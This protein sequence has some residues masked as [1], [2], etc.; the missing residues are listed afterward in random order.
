MKEETISV[1]IK[2]LVKSGVY[3]NEEVALKDIV[4]N[5]IE[6][7]ISNYE[8]T[9]KKIENKYN[10]SFEELTDELKNE[11]HFEQEEDWMDI[12]GAIVMKEA[13]EKARESLIKENN[14]V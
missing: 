5:H 11:A 13:W 14:Y 9:I 8:K 6:S 3:K 2:P 1:I 4:V 10:M 12:K 7:K